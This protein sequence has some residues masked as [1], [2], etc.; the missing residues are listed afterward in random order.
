LVENKRRGDFDYRFSGKK[1]AFSFGLGARNEVFRME[2]QP[3]IGIHFIT[4]GGRY[5][6]IK[7]DYF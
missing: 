6:S 7:E 2:V 4:V 1:E 3:G 5:I